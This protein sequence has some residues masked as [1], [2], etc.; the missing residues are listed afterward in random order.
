M[1]E[2]HAMGLGTT[3]PLSSLY[4]CFSSNSA[5][6]NSTIPFSFHL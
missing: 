6:L 3:D 5:G 2:T 1:V 4:T